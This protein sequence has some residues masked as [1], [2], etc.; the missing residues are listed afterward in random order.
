VSEPPDVRAWR[1]VEVL[2]PLP[3][4]ARNSVHLARRGDERLVIRVSRRALD[5]LAWELDLL[6]A[7]AAAGLAVPR[8]VPTDDGRRH[9]S[10]VLVQRFIEG[11]RPESSEDWARVVATNGAVHEATPGWPPRPVS[12]PRGS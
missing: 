8:S 6:D 12:V 9:D 3:G 10:G 1:G 11:H 7:L 2:E 4:G 5:S